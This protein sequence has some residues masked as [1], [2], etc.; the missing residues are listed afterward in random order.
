MKNRSSRFKTGL[1]GLLVGTA[2][3]LGITGIV[4][5]CKSSDSSQKP[6][7]NGYNKTNVIE[8]DYEIL[9][10][11]MLNKV[12]KIADI[13][14][15]DFEI[16]DKKITE[17]GYFVHYEGKDEEGNEFDIF[18][19]RPEY[20]PKTLEVG[21]LFYNPKTNSSCRFES[22][23]EESNGENILKIMLGKEGELYNFKNTSGQ[24]IPKLTALIRQL[25]S[26]YA[27]NKSN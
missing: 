25:E 19:K 24:E 27:P 20:A 6:A 7:G 16:S 22:Q 9:E 23:L 4:T 18:V 12:Q 5:G 3:T 15:N 10:K 8:T 1:A 11:N 17:K 13:N 2:L 21:I 26:K 14:P